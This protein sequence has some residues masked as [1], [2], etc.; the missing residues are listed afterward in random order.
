MPAPDEI[1][2]ASSAVERS[3]IERVAGSLA[4]DRRLLDAATLVGEPPEGAALVTAL[5]EHAEEGS[6]V[7]CAGVLERIANFVGVVQALVRLAAER[8]VTVV[9]A[10]PNHE[11][12]DADDDRRSTWGSGA[13]AELRGLLPADHAA[14]QVLALRG[15]ALV[16]AEDTARID[17]TIDADARATV[18]AMFVLA[19][20]PRAK[21]LVATAAVAAADLSAE[22]ASD[23]ARTAELEVLR[24]RL[25]ALEP[26]PELMPGNGGRP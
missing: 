17:V 5:H 14:Y 16:P 8:D 19:F 12:A 4:D 26:R 6:V 21:R 1:R 23:R 15:A 11:F 2:D 25:R 24:A 20:G 18:P 3:L 7:V 9:V 22:R 13:V 10:V